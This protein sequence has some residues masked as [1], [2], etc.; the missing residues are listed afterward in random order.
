MPR[1]REL[2]SSMPEDEFSSYLSGMKNSPAK[3]Y[4]TNRV[5]GQIRWYDKKSRRNRY[6]YMAAMAFCVVMS[7]LIPI[8][9][10]NIDLLTYKVIMTVFGSSVTAVSSVCAF[11]RFRELWI[12]YRTQCELLKSTLHRF[13]SN[14]GEFKNSPEPQ[15]LLVELCE[16]YMMKETGVWAARTPRDGQ[17][18]STGS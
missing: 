2:K 6:G 5:C 14:C 17:F 7:G 1:I 4:I 9:T 3:D 10:S 15:K 8:L 13:F 11:C 18:P 16:G 12:L